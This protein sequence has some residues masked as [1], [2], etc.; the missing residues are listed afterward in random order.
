MRKH[1]SFRRIAKWVGLV[2]CLVIVCIFVASLWCWLAVHGSNSRWSFVVGHG[3]CGFRWLTGYAYEGE[4]R[5]V[6]RQYEHGPEFDSDSLWFR[7]WTDRDYAGVTVP[8]WFPFLIVAVPTL[9]L[10]FRDRGRTK[11]GHCR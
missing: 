11:P 10:W 2:A 1:V 4:F 3:I 6:V 8:L 7:S 5:A 9:W